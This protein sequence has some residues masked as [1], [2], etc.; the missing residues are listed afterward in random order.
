MRTLSAVLFLSAV[1]PGGAYADETITFFETVFLPTATTITVG[2]TV[3][4][5]WSA[6]DHIL[7][8]GVSSDPADDPGELFEAPI[9]VGNQSFSYTYNLPGTYSFFDALHETGLV[10]TII[11]E[12]HIT[13][14]QV[15]D[16]AF[17]P[18]DI[19]V[20]V[21]DQ[22]RWQWIEGIHT[23]T[24]G[25]SSNPSDNPGAL[26]DAPSTVGPATL[27]QTISV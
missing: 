5:E 12:P 3:T 8:S 4:W 14:V 20:F 9:D 22:V 25:A 24:S 7:T 1:L 18:Q 15:V 2:E 19:D 6:G 21:G 13:V 27:S 10:G 23:V 16:I 11:V 17:T 26:F